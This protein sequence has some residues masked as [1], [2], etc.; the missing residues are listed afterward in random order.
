MLGREFQW[1]IDSLFLRPTFSAWEY[2][3]F[4]F[5]YGIEIKNKQMKTLACPLKN[6]FEL[7]LQFCLWFRD[8]FL[9]WLLLLLYLDSFY[10]YIKYHIYSHILNHNWINNYLNLDLPEVFLTESPWNCWRGYGSILLASRIYID[11]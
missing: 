2:V 1:K 11:F 6:F 10:Y 5:K 8:F 9:L 3:D 4:I 7:R